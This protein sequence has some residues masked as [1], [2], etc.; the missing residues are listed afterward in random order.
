[1]YN[2]YVNS[3]FTYNPRLL[4]TYSRQI[5]TGTGYTAYRALALVPEEC[6]GTRLIKVRSLVSTY[7]G[8][9]ESVGSLPYALGKNGVLCLQVRYDLAS[10]KPVQIE[11]NTNYTISTPHIQVQTISAVHCCGLTTRTAPS[12]APHL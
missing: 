3:L 7:S 10:R 6:P 2:N 9:G 4:F 1:M 12:T 8:L 5:A 11:R